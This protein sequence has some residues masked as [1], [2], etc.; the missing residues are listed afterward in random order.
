[1]AAVAAA[2]TASCLDVRRLDVTTLR[3]LVFSGGGTRGLSYVGALA[4]LQRRGLHIARRGVLLGTAGTSIGSLIACLVAAGF[5]AEELTHTFCALDMSSLF[6]FNL[7]LILLRFGLDDSGRLMA[8]IDAQLHKKLGPGAA[9]Q[10]WTLADM[11]ARTGVDLVVVATDLARDVPVYLRAASHPRLPVS[12]AVAASMA[13]PPVFA[14][15]SVGSQLMV[16]GGLADNFPMQLFPA[17]QTLGMRVH[18]TSAFKLDTIDQY[19]SRVAYCALSASEAA[20]WSRL[21]AEARARTVEI[22]TGNIQTVELR[23]D[24]AEKQMVIAAGRDAVEAFFEHFRE[25]APKS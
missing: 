2:A 23:L 17:A 7:A 8:F 11:R 4:A 25:P 9:G 19:F 12:E 14:P 15:I 21:P 3:Y 24:D 18:W 20:Q 13:I 22:N 6:S 10:R 1:M 16:D 5:S